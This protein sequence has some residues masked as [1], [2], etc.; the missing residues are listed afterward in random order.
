VRTAQAAVVVTIV[1]MNWTFPLQVLPSSDL[2]SLLLFDSNRARAGG[3]SQ[4]SPVLSSDCVT[5][6][7]QPRLESFTGRR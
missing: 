7:S 5:F 1:A 3:Y 2:Q 6:S 4:V